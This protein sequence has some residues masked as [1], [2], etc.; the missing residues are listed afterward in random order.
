MLS[1]GATLAVGRAAG[2]QGA[3]VRGDPAIGATASPFA[4]PGV[5][6]A[7]P[8]RPLGGLLL[9]NVAI[10]FGGLSG[11][12]L[13]AGL[14]LTAISDLGRFL[15]ARLVLHEDGA[16]TSLAGLRT[17]RLRDGGGAPLPRGSAGDAESLARLPDGTWLVGFE[18]WHRIRAYRR[19]DGPGAHVEAPPGI[20]EAPRNG[21][22][23]SLAVLA[24]GRWLAITERH[25]PAETPGLRHAWIGGPGAGPGRWAPIAYRPTAAEFDPADATPLPDGGA[26]VLERRFSLFGGFRGRLV[27]V[28]AAALAAARAGGVI[29]GE[30][31]LRLGPP[32]PADNWEGV[33]AVRLANGRTLVALV[34]DDNQSMLQQ[35]MLLLFLLERGKAAIVQR[36]NAEGVN[37]A[38]RRR[39]SRVFQ[40]SSAGASGR[41]VKRA[42]S[43]ASSGTS[44][45]P[46]S[47]SSAST[48]PTPGP[49]MKPWPEKPKAWISPGVV[50]LGPITGSTSGI[51]P[52]MPV[53]ERMTIASARRGI[54]ATAFAIVAKPGAGNGRETGTEGSLSPR[55]PPKMTLP[56]GIWRR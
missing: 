27:R 17:G 39:H 42:M 49:S 48:A 47:T 12:H 16:P 32:W 40:T 53:Q 4:L 18:R 36:G 21:G 34:S 29:E 41:C 22:L 7:G 6:S 52:S 28:P 50:R 24:D 1:L 3:V 54:S 11:L 23:E 33:S 55:P 14:R 51:S 19:L 38:A 2:A 10:G 30:E 35:S 9:D 15:T 45:R 44:V 25:G 26:L 56:R 8:L 46:S 37:S 20:E 31:L 13:D 43:K 5:P